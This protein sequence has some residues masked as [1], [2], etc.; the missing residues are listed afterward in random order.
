MHVDDFIDRRKTDPYASFF[1]MLQRLPASLQF[2]FA[3]FIEQYQLYCTYQGERYRVTGASSL[4]DIWLTQ[5]FSQSTGYRKRVDV[6]ECSQ[7]S[8]EAEIPEELV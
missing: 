7:F 3:E 4:G 5:D 2:K 1:F 6:W 8:S